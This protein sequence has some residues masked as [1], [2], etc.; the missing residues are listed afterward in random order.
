MKKDYLIHFTFLTAFFVII[1]LFK[2]WLSF[3]YIV[4]WI[5]GALGTF[6]PDTDYLF[7]AYLAEPTDA[8]SREVKIHISEG[9]YAQSADVFLEGR[10]PRNR[11]TFHNSLFQLVFVVFSFLVITSSGSLLGRGIVLGFLLHLFIDQVIEYMEKGGIKE[12]FY[13][14]PVELGSRDRKWYLIGNGLVLLIFGTL[15]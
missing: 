1:T 10:V 5:G 3:E 13:N 9:K 12:W 8:I 14:F 11:L 2:G 4:F 15:L 7:Y 6:L